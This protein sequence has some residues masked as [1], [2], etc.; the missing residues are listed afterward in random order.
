M[1]TNSPPQIQ[2]EFPPNEVIHTLL[3]QRLRQKQAVGLIVGLIDSRGTRVVTAGTTGNPNCPAV[4]EQTLFEIGSI[5]K[6]FTAAALADAIASG[7]VAMDDP[8]AKFLPLPP[9]GIGDRTLKELVTHTSGLPRL[10]SGFTWWSNL[11]RHLRDP[12]ANYSR[13]DL[14]ACV[15]AL[16][17][18]SL[19]RGKFHYSNLAVGILGNVLAA[20]ENTDYAGLITQRVTKP[21]GMSRT[22]LNIPQ[23][24]QAFI[25][26]P[27]SKSL[28]PTPLWTMTAIAGAGA[29]RSSM[30]DMFQFASAAL[31]NTPPLTASMFQRLA[32]GA[33][34]NQSVGLGW[35]LETG[36]A[37]QLAWHNGGTGGSR[38]FL[39]VELKSRRA[40]ILLGN[41]PHSLDQLGVR[42]LLGFNPS[43][44]SL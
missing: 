36:P 17:G 24:E 22:Y 37:Y 28:R 29:L 40:V 43:T 12:Y 41:T 16:K 10:P 8:L 34:P 1:P 30:Q 6:L 13:R 42:L 38:S 39:G 26:Q 7:S 9:D 21:L 2:A 20:R 27:Y 18:K 19:P 3:Q 44:N 23:S 33:R 4:D 5:T 25:A 15:K 11:L 31:A 35:M 32:Q 14:E